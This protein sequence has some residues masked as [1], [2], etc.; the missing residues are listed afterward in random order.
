MET[1]DGVGTSGTHG[2]YGNNCL[3][4]SL[5]HSWR[6]W[7]IVLVGWTVTVYGFS[8]GYGFVWDDHRLIVEN[9]FVR[10]PGS[11]LRV[12]STGF[13][14]VSGRQYSLSGLYWRPFVS[15]AYIAQ[16]KL[17]GLRSLGWHAVNLGLHVGCVVLVARWVRQRLMATGV[18]LGEASR[19]AVVGAAVF[20]VHPSRAESVAWVS[21]STDLWAT[22]F[23]L[24]AFEAWR[25]NTARAD[26]LAAVCVFLAV[27]CKEFAVVLPAVFAVERWGSKPTEQKN[28]PRESAKRLIAPMVA[29][30]AVLSLRVLLVGAPWRENTESVGF[31][32]LRAL[33]SLGEAL[34]WVFVPISPGALMVPTVLNRDGTVLLPGGSIALGG[35]FLVALGG[36]VIASRRRLSL[37][38]WAVELTVFTLFLAPA[39]NLS[40]WTAPAFVSPRFL[41]APLIGLAAVVARVFVM[42]PRARVRGAS[43]VT[44]GIIVAL[45][46]LTLDFASHFSDD[47]TLWRA[48]AQSNPEACFAHQQLSVRLALVGRRREALDAARAELACRERHGSTRQLALAMA[49]VALR[50]ADNTPD[51]DQGLLGEL[52]SFLLGFD[53]NSRGVAQIDSNDADL[54]MRADLSHEDR[55]ALWMGLLPYVA[56]LDARTLDLA[57]ALQRLRAVLAVAPREITAV[58]NLTVVYG[59]LERWPEAREMCTRGLSMA[60]G[61]PSVRS[62]CATVQRSAREASEPRRNDYDRA[63]SVGE[64]HLALGA[65]ELARRAVEGAYR[66]HPER[67]GALVVLV[68]ADLADGLVDRARERLREATV[69]VT[70]G[71]RETLVRLR[72]RVERD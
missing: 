56:I 33:A 57:G 67:A 49:T 24:L 45:S 44:V 65:R 71:D 54:H 20:A 48:E 64:R 63:V 70:E 4:K 32:G 28:E 34:R 40:P 12:F 1:T 30:A 46:A 21:G 26:V 58:V 39:L 16:W 27:C 62:V 6:F 17:F 66:A 19:A 52:K 11:L 53:P 10:E 59:L 5:W 60:P 23:V 29:V 42:V 61:N 15:G 50:A 2:S 18:S 69:R 41:Y 25:R 13:W 55:E 72:A 68:E 8:L 9:R 43:L 35:M 51:A 3:D 36:L 37:R 47:L 22:V 31:V 14:E 7:V 38:P